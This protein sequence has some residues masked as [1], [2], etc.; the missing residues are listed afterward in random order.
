MLAAPD[1]VEVYAVPMENSYE[2]VVKGVKKGGIVIYDEEGR[3]VNAIP[4]VNGKAIK[5]CRLDLT[6]GRYYYILVDS[7]DSVLSKGILK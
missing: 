3:V 1:S 6:G 4:V 7:R 2:I 5:P